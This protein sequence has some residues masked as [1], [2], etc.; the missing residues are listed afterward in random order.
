MEKEVET[1]TDSSTLEES[2][3]GL[4]DKA[5][6]AGNLI[7]QLRDEKKSLGVRLQQVENELQ[8]IKDA[9]GNREQELKRLRAEY[10]QMVSSNGQNAF[11]ENEKENLKNKIRDLIAKINS[12]L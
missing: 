5:R 3:K 7:V 10:A 2:I 4:W 8:S 12:H 9:L 6:T 11:T 1:A